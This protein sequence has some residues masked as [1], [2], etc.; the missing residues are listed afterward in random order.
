MTV[1]MPS[2]E[3][4]FHVYENAGHGFNCDHRASYQPE[5]AALAWGR[6]RDFLQRTIG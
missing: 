3:V 6:T 1:W 2:W 4:G 5:A